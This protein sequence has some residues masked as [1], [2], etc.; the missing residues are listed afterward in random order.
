MMPAR[1]P[2]GTP[3]LRPGRVVF[4]VQLAE[5]SGAL[6]RYADGTAQQSVE[7]FDPEDLARKYCAEVAGDGL[8]DCIQL[9]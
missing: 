8:G 7:S 4:L 9:E 2:G 1:Q 5:F 3:A 6:H